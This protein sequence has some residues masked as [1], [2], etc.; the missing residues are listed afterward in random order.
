MPTISKF[1][2]ISI[3]LYYND[4][5]PPHFHVIYS[6]FMTRIE[7]MTGEYIR[8]DAPLPPSKEKDVMKWLDIHKDDMINAW[9]AC[10]CKMAPRKIPPLY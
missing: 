8:S 3:Y 7:I 6:G 1:G 9:D 2:G 5:D 10:R 4:H